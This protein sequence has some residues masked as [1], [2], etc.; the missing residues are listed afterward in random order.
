MGACL[1]KMHIVCHELFILD[2]MAHAPH[3]VFI[4]CLKR[5]VGMCCQ[6]VGILRQ[7]EATD[8]V[9][10]LLIHGMTAH[11][12]VI[13][14]EQWSRKV[15]VEQA[16]K[17]GVH[18]S[19]C[20]QSA[21]QNRHGNIMLAGG[22][23]QCFRGKSSLEDPDSVDRRNIPGKLIGIAAGNQQRCAGLI[24][25]I[26]IGGFLGHMLLLGIWQSA[27]VGDENL[28]LYAQ[29]FRCQCRDGGNGAKAVC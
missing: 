2:G 8:I 24:M 10:H 15:V 17:N 20:H 23:Q 28:C 18:H 22:I 21:E 29:V 6:W 14:S 26:R 25:Q 1:Y 16:I 3:Q 12:S 7:V 11:T 27:I 13:Y 5:M 9:C 19:F 4:Q